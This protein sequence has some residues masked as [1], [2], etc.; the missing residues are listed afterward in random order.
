MRA[1]FFSLLALP[2]AEYA[3]AASTC[4]DLKSCADA[5]FELTGQRYVWNESAEKEKL[6]MS[7]ETELTKV[8]ADLVFTAL[9]DQVGMARLP[10]GDGKTYRIMRSNERKELE[11]PIVDASAE[12]EPELPKTWD[13]VTMRYHTKTKELPS[14]IE[15]SYRLHVPREA[16]MQADMNSGYLLI[17]GPAPMVRHMYGIVKGADN[18]LTS[19]TRKA[20][21]EQEKKWA[22]Q[23][24]AAEKK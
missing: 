12:K 14:L 2:L 10:V 1:L 13:W 9:L 22:E 15:Q 19:E 8:N 6:R 16:R 11:M 3:H 7:P 17:A 21:A 5:M 23:R 24:K 18:P 4:K 20:L